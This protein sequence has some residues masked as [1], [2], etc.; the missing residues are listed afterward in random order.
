MANFKGIPT[1]IIKRQGI[2]PKARTAA[3]RGDVCIQ[4]KDALTGKIVEEER[5]HNM[6][7]NGIESAI[8]GCP[9]DINKID[10]GASSTPRTWVY[11]PMYQKLLGGLLL[12]P[13]AL[14]NDANLMFPSFAN[15]PTGFASMDS[16][17]Q[18]DSRQGSYDA[19]SSG[20]VTNGFRHV[21]SWGS[22]FG[23]GT[24]ASLGL[25]PMFCEGWCKDVTK[26]LRPSTLLADN[27]FTTY[28]MY[29]QRFVAIGE[30]G[31][32]TITRERDN[33]LRFSQ[34][35][36][37]GR[38][39]PHSL[40]LLQNM[41]YNDT[42]VDYDTDYSAYPFSNE[43][44]NGYTWAVHVPNLPSNNDIDGYW[45]RYSFQ[46]TDDYVYVVYHTSDNGSSYTVTKLDITDGSVVSEN[47][48]TFSGSFGNGVPVYYNGYIYAPSSVAGKIYK[49]N[50][51]N[52]ADVTEITHSSIPVNAH[53]RYTGGQW[54]YNQ[55]F[56]LD[57]SCDTI[58]GNTGI[59][60][61]GYSEGEAYKEDG[62]GSA[63]P[64]FDDGMWLV[65]TFSTRS[66]IYITANVKQ[67]GL[68]T[69]FD[70]QNAVVKTP[71]KQMEVQYSITQQ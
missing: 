60:G 65:G 6:L 53:L 49:C 22:A 63:I 36:F 58:E 45:R 26:R 12:F 71:D 42:R 54:I 37:Y 67:W 11:T 16:Y 21:F 3:I 43:H 61:A 34:L 4:L 50:T 57:A 15:S 69:H 20:V 29:Y 31:F 23:N 13:Q 19:V 27:A 44:R 40:N 48:Y 64:L 66:N 51:A 1:P 9:F 14:G 18:G 25:A 24:I 55:Y 10:G 2:D 46:V 62:Y 5:G 41:P 33:N 35:C 7:T 28:A 30:N 32:C 17:Q 8:N 70:L 39:R 59:I 47:T 38:Q 68:M 52:V 56:I